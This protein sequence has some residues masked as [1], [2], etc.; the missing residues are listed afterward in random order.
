M[1]IAPIEVRTLPLEQLT[2][3]P[4]NPRKVLKPADAAYR[5]LRASLL[6]F[7]LVEP[8]V[9]NETTGHVVGGHARLRIL[10]ELG[11]TEVPVS[12]VRLD[13]TREKSLNVVLNNQEAQGRYD[14]TKL[15]DLLLELHSVSQ[16]SLS[17]FDE[18]MLSNLQL[19]PVGE[20]P[21]DEREAD[22]VEVVL[23]FN[24]AQFTNLGPQLD[25]LVRQWGV[26]VHVKQ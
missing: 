17:G 8:L 11:V 20:L 15:R 25:E 14:P 22:R 5:K 13:T 3:S 21:A 12:V 6:E 16:L 7:G 18:T 26:E 2:P 9:W 10:H 1:S 23:V 19:D 24:R 4:Y